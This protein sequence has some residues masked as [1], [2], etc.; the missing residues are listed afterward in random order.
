MADAFVAFVENLIYGTGLAPN[1]S[2]QD[3]LAANPSPSGL[4]WLTHNI[5][6]MLAA[7]DAWLAS[8]GL[9]PVTPW[10]GVVRAPWDSAQNLPLGSDLD[11]TFTGITTV[12]QLGQVLRD[13]YSQVATV[14]AELSGLLKA[15][16][17]HRYWSYMKWSRDMRTR[18]LGMPVFPTGWVYDREGT[19]LSAQPFLDTF[20]D[21]HRNW[22]VGSTP[23]GQVTPGFTS[24]AGQRSLRGLASITPPEEFLRFHREHMELFFRWLARTGQPPPLPIDMGLT[25]GWP[26]VPGSPPWTPPSPWAEDETVVTTAPGAPLSGETSEADIGSIEVGYHVAGHGENTDIGPLSHNNYVPRFHNWHGWIDS[27]W[28]WREARFAQSI[29]ATG[30]RTHVF[31]PVLDDD[32]DFPGLTAVSIV[33]NPAAAADTIYPANA[34]GGLDL[35]TG[36]GTLRMKMYVHDPYGRTLRMRLTAE[37]LDATG[38]PAGGPPVTMLRTIGPA[39]DH[40]LDSEFSEDIAFTD[41][42]R[43]DDPGRANPA[44]GFVNGRI[45]ITGNLWVPN[46]ATPD[47]PTT[48]PEAGFVHEDIVYLDLVN[49][50]SGPEVLIYQNLSSFSQDQVNSAM[51]G[52]TASFE[53]A[54]YVVT[55][56]R[57]TPPVPLPTWPP[58]VANEVKGLI[59]GLQP[60][61][62]LFGD[63]THQ[64]DVV[65]WQESVD[66]PFM[67]V[68]VELEGL[69]DME[70]P[71]LPPEFTQRLTWRY[72]IAFAAVND[73][74]TGLSTGDQR[75]ARLRVT[76][77]DR[78][79]NAAT[80]EAK[81]KLFVDANPY[82]IDGAVPW[83]SV[84]T[85][86]FS[87]DEGQTRLGETIAA[88]QPLPYL[89]AILNRL[90]AGTTGAETFET[91]A[92]D[93]PGT[94]LEY[95][96]A[97]Q[98]LS[99]GT[100]TKVYN[101]A[102]AKVRLQGAAGAQRV[103][104]SFRLFRYSEPS[105]LFD[106]TKGYRAFSDGAGRVV[107][108][109]GFESETA[110]ASL[111]SI[112]FFAQARVDTSLSSMEN[113]QDPLNVHDFPPGPT[114][115]RV[116]YFGA[117][118]DINDPN[119]RLPQSYAAATPNG[120]FPAATVQSLRTLMRDYHQCMVA[121]IRYDGDPTDPLASPAASDNLAQRNL[122]ILESSNPG[123]VASR[124]VQHSFEIDLLRPPAKRMDDAMLR[125]A[126]ATKGTIGHTR[127][128]HPEAEPEAGGDHYEPAGDGD[129]AEPSEMQATLRCLQ[130]GDQGIDPDGCCSHC[131][132]VGEN[133]PLEPGDG[134]GFVSTF[135]M[136]DL[137]WQ[138]AMSL[139]M[140]VP[141]HETKGHGGEDHHAMAREMIPLAGRIVRRAFP[142]VFHPTS[143]SETSALA[144]E[145]M[146]T[147]NDLPKQSAVTLFFPTVPAE[148]IVS[149]R[150]LRHAP[151]T[152]RAEGNGMLRLAVT[153]VTF[154]PIPPVPGGRVGGV[155]T[156]TLPEGMKAGQRFVI[157][158]TQLQAG[159]QVQ[160]G[161]FRVEIVV[162]KAAGLLP[163]A[164]RHVELLLDQL[165]LTDRS[166]RWR[167]I[168]LRRLETERARARAL[169]AEAGEEW[170]DPTVWTD[171]A[172]EEHP[173]EG[174]KIRA[175]LERIHILDDRDPWLKGAGEI[176][177]DVTVRTEN[178]GGAEQHTRLPHEGHYRISSGQSLMVDRPIFE[179]FAKDH[180]AVRIAAME[181]DLFDPDD[182]L[183]VYTRVLACDSE[184]WFGG[185]GAGDERLDPERVGYFEVYYRIER[186]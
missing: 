156:I 134:L 169:A 78:A 184:T 28:W 143:W 127:D 149:L 40:P 95:A 73:A 106:T 141:H 69:P 6:Q 30:E 91:L 160:N 29:P 145:L 157:D 80:T 148:Q 98:D 2:H 7:L 17:S 48:S 71:T 66:A 112:P 38:A 26:P 10:D 92:T 142:F 161:G 178:N 35:T 103:R 58:L 97:R 114:A 85:R 22:H 170:R 131:G 45:K 113:Q 59:V 9:P 90:N 147:W 124:T 136:Q 158:V 120:P 105:L 41:A 16:F 182:N 47:D 49:E 52:G 46:A 63:V 109:L 37:V 32:S 3:W 76:E 68:T 75:F 64:P 57:S 96:T 179:G 100:S 23:S 62:G 180:L 122:T 155:M 137:V 168:L 60:T 101:F 117:W 119:A 11:G 27:Q 102:L 5:D 150:N 104:A 138:E 125:E 164:A 14:S 107:P 163:A 129:Q 82:M 65:L 1:P 144:D 172:G 132:G 13:R 173:V 83:L 31:R 133:G 61:S 56:D 19:I 42:F 94:A 135:T 126:F 88:D 154:I 146:I 176:D 108:L 20:N 171:E 183:G 53:D 8:Q 167:P 118:L 162:A 123:S 24:T 36:A 55:Q 99:T 34:V 77:R 153:D 159:S 140:S 25:G 177:F 81:I 87:I 121:E 39:G 70:D 185:Y 21:L 74:F 151:R 43:S 165:S 79:G 4:A 72:R 166:D 12:E 116:W 152:V 181:R 139:A 93:G 115:E 128:F 84:D 130:C 175:V 89:S 186:A 54:F 67:G 51:S 44:V 174:R 33:R 18:F 86:V 111:L 110:G 15:P 50:K